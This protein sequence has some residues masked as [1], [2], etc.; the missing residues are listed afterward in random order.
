MLTVNVPRR[1]GV[2]VS[3]LTHRFWVYRSSILGAGWNWS[4]LIKIGRNYSKSVKSSRNW[5]KS[6]EIRRNRS[7]LVEI[8]STLVKIGR[9][10]NSTKTE[11]R[12]W[13]KRYLA[14]IFRQIPSLTNSLFAK[15]HHYRMYVLNIP[16]RY[17]LKSECWG[18]Y[19][20]ESYTNF[21]YDYYPRYKNC[22]H[23]ILSILQN[24]FP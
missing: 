22:Q 18:M 23:E 5:S 13:R 15:F 6:V 3:K 14:N 12:I 1:E 21:W 17:K 8:G 7:T 16:S 9:K 11:H 4:K 10:R 20:R 19:L 24:A 2:C